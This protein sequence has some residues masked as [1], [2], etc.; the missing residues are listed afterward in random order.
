MNESSRPDATLREEPAENEDTVYPL[1]AFPSL[2]TFEET[3]DFPALSVPAKKTSELRRLLKSVLFYRPKMKTIFED[4][5]DSTRRILLLVKQANADNGVSSDCLDDPVFDQEPVKSLLADT[6]NDC[7]K[8]VHPVRYTYEEHDA[9]ELL[10]KIL[11]K[12]TKEIPSAFETVGSLIHINLRDELLPYKYWIGKILL[13]KHQPRIKTVVNKIGTI[14][15]EYR[16]FGMEVLAGY[17]GNGWSE[18]TV[19]EENCTFRLDFRKVYWNSR[20][21]GEHRRLVDVIR[22]DA[23]E[24]KRETTTVIDLMAGV[25]PFAVP[26]TATTNK[27]SKAMASN[28]KIR[29][30]ANDL[31]PESFRYLKINAADNKCENLT[32]FNKDARSFL[33]DIQNSEGQNNDSQQIETVDHVIMNLPASAPEFLDAF[34]GWKLKQCPLVHVHCFCPKSSQANDHEE[35]VTRCEKALGC[36]INEADIHVVRDVSPTK[37]MLCV[38]FRLPDAARSVP[39]L[40][41]QQECP[42]SATKKARIE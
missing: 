42:E 35:A 34:R 5:D 25:G 28:G 9:D 22:K 19:K 12:E 40:C 3:T 32:C 13:D 31:N 29:V 16:T 6:E 23:K 15:T 2:E 1:S 38:T 21:G 37:N 4:P 26:L 7:R 27:G 41:Q 10:R 11:P 18:V 33:Q 14:E 30:Y 39:S 36:T 17:D 8:V 24:S 20:L